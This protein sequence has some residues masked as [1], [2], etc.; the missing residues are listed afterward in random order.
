MTI[1]LFLVT[2]FF[3]PFSLAVYL[4]GLKIGGFKGFILL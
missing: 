4:L 2:L 3:H 1:D